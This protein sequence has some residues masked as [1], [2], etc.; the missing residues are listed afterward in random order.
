[1]EERARLEALGYVASPAAAPTSQLGVVGGP[2]PKDQMPLLKPLFE[3]M[4]LL[5]HDR[6]REALALL[7]PLGALGWEL[8]LLRSRAAL[9]AGPL[10]RAR[11]S[12]DR[13]FAL[14]AGPAPLVMLGRIAEAEG[15]PERAQRAYAQALALD[16]V[17]APAF[18]GLGRVAEAA[19]RRDEARRRY[20]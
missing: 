20:E 6:A 15:Q 2:D 10:A 14:F 7:A 18:V 8:E 19:G 4:A 16:P 3:A 12:A 5:A 1:P 11:R 13:A 17:H 9:G